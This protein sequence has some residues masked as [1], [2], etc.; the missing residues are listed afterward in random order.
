MR[1]IFKPHTAQTRKDAYVKS[2]VNLYRINPICP[3]R[4]LGPPHNAD[5]IEKLQIKLMWY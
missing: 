5:F 1:A 3:A 2:G 4:S